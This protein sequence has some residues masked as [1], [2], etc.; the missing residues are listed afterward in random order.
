MSAASAVLSL[1]LV[2]FGDEPLPGRRIGVIG[3]AVAA[4]ASRVSETFGR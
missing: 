4:A 3:E 1:S 2:T